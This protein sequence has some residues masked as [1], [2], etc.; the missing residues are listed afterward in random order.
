MITFLKC[1]GLE[2]LLIGMF[3]DICRLFCDSPLVVVKVL[4]LHNTRTKGIPSS[5]HFINFS[6]QRS[7]KEYNSMLCAV[8]R[9]SI[10]NVRVH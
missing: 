3:Y 7:K 8:V 10:V 9:K 4:S 5:K 2:I 1:F 6:F